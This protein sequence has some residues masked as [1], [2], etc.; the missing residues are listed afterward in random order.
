MQNGVSS[1]DGEPKPIR[2][3]LLLFVLARAVAGAFGGVAGAL[4]LAIV[5]DVVPEQRRG[6]AMGMVMSSFSVASICGV[7]IGL[8]LA[9]TFNWHVPFFALAGFSL[10]VLFAAAKV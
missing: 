4:I 3:R 6:A 8:V 5:G 2:E 7:P 10:V 9:S 1:P